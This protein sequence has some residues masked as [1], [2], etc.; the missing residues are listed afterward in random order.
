MRN[1]VI[2]HVLKVVPGGSK[3]EGNSYNGV[4]NEIECRIYTKGS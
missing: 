2:Q 1:L 4:T 3:A